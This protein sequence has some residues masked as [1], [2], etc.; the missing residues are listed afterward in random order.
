MNQPQLCSTLVLAVGKTIYNLRPAAVAESRLWEL[1]CTAGPANYG[2]FR[3]A[4]S[5]LERTRAFRKD[6]SGQ[7]VYCDNFR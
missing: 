5:I 1:V 6:S 7:W 3:R 4:L 2:H